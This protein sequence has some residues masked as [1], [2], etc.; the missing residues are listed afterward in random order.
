MEKTI[1]PFTCFNLH[2]TNISGQFIAEVMRKSSLCPHPQFIEAFYALE[3]PILVSGIKTGGV[4]DPNGPN[5]IKTAG[6]DGNGFHGK[7][8]EIMNGTEI[9]ENKNET[10]FLLNK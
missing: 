6:F 10:I 9:A 1:G 8:T 5:G 3:E 2:F 4:N 7:K